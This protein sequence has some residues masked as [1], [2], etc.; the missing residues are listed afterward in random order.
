MPEHPATAQ[1]NP[2]AVVAPRADQRRQTGDSTHGHAAAIMTLQ[3]VV[4]ADGRRPRR[5]IV[6]RQ[7]DDALDR[8]TGDLGRAGRRPLL[9]ARRKLVETQRVTTHVVGVVKPLADD[10]VHNGQ[11]QRA[12]G[13]GADGDPL[14]GGLGGARVGRVDDE[15][16]AAGL[17][18]G[19]DEG[20]QMLVAGQRVA[21]PDQDKPGVGEILRQHPLSR[22]YRV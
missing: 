9:Q 14:V 18:R 6:A 20:P 4:D 8:H 1:L 5:G 17:A 7:G 12:V 15:D 2:A 11:R 21:A 13:A 19:L 3:A 10:D 22:A 16:A